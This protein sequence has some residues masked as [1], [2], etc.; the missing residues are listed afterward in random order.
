M[1][2]MM[3]TDGRPASGFASSICLER[4]GMMEDCDE[5][6]SAMVTLR[7]LMPSSCQQ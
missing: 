2:R 1:A 5:V 6:E 7:S 3:A 4:V